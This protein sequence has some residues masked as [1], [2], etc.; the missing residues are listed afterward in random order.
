MDEMKAPRKKGGAAIAQ[1]APVIA[2]AKVRIGNGNVI[3]N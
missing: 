2:L 3:F 1:S